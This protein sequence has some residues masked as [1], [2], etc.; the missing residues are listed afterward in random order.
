[1]ACLRRYAPDFLD[2]GYDMLA[3][4]DSVLTRHNAPL[5]SHRRVLDLGCGC[6][7]VIRALGHT[8][9]SNAIELFGVDV[10]AEAIRWCQ[11]HYGDLAKFSTTTPEPPVPLS[12]GLFDLVYAISLFTHLPEALQ[13]LWLAEIRRLVRPGGY[14]LL[15]V[16]GRFHLDTVPAAHKSELDKKGFVY[17]RTGDTPGLPSYYQTAWHSPPYLREQWGRFFHVVDIVLC[18]RGSAP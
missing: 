1:M 17:A 9:K 18:R 6:G 15:T 8:T 13:F 14:A 16:H 4:M 5:S 12:P 10:D 2:S 3:A 7:R 11:S